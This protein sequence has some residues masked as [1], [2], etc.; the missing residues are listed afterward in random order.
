[1]KEERGVVWLTRDMKTLLGGLE[2]DG[3]QMLEWV[4]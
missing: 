1:M 2:G 3:A 4:L